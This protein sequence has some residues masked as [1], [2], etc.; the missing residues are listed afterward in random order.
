MAEYTFV[1]CPDPLETSFIEYEE[2]SHISQTTDEDSNI[3]FVEVKLCPASSECTSFSV[4]VN[5]CPD[6]ESCSCPYRVRDFRWY[7]QGD[8]HIY[9][10]WVNPDKCILKQVR[11]SK[12]DPWDNVFTVLYTHDISEGDPGTPIYPDDDERNPPCPGCGIGGDD[13]HPTGFETRA[14]VTDITPGQ[15][16]RLSGYFNDESCGGIETEVVFGY[17]VYETTGWTSGIIAEIVDPVTRLFKVQKYEVNSE[18]SLILRSH[19]MYASDYYSWEVGDPVMISKRGTGFPN[20]EPY[21]S[22]EINNEN[23]EY[24]GEDDVDEN[25]ISTWNITT[26]DKVDRIDR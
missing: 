5:L 18:G 19:L 21:G 25:G 4:I 10:S 26:Y 22:S 8:Q 3:S 2:G 15:A 6:D 1:L 20:D 24:Y 17:L 13:N 23:M 7:D 11:L 9:I 12:R 14:Y 16:Y